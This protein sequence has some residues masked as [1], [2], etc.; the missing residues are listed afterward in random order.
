IM[1][2]F[3]SI[4]VDSDD[5]SSLSYLRK[6]KQRK[7]IKDAISSHCPY[8]ATSLMISVARGHK[9]SFLLLDFKFIFYEGIFFEAVLIQVIRHDLMHLGLC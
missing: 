3:Y 6:K 5:D 9:S 2:R 7:C 8:F 1:D 4:F